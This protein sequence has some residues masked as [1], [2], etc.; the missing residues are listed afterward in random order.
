MNTV[1]PGH[2]LDFATKTERCYLHSSVVLLRCQLGA[3]VGVGGAALS[4]CWKDVLQLLRCPLN[5]YL[6]PTQFQAGELKT[7]P[8]FWKE[9]EQRPEAC[10][11]C[12][13]VDRSWIAN[14]N[15]WFASVKICRP[16]AIAVSKL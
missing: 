6:F 8:M 11:F 4:K 14:D 1:R 2:F 15:S 7:I 5:P 13:E 10:L 12:M 3:G 9:S 16:R